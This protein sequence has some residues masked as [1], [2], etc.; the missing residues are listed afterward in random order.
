MIV[1]GKLS[2]RVA[3]IELLNPTLKR[4]RFVPEGRRNIPHLTA[5]GACARHSAGY[6]PCLAER[7]F[8]W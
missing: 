6:G 8:G 7:L 1:E 5:R 2:A 3:E 4:F